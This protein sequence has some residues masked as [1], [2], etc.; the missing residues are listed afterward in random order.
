M[1]SINYAPADE[2]MKVHGIGQEIVAKIEVMRNAKQWITRDDFLKIPHTRAETVDLLDFSKN[3]NTEN[4]V[5]GETTDTISGLDRGEE[6]RSLSAVGSSDPRTS[7]GPNSTPGPRPVSYSSQDMR[8][9]FGQGK[10]TI[11]DHGPPT[12][13]SHPPPGSWAYNPGQPPQASWSHIQSH[14]PQGSWS[15]PQGPP[16]QVAWSL[17]QG[18]RP[19]QSV[20]EEQL[21]RIVKAQL[22]IQGHGSIP[23]PTSTTT[24]N[25]SGYGV[26]QAQT[27][28]QD[29]NL[30]RH[31]HRHENW[32]NEHSIRTPQPKNLK[33]PTSIFFDGSS[34]FNFFGPCSPNSST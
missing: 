16:P 23:P 20:D 11:P 2:L 32:D 33:P 19:N 22:Q 12:H 29:R 3:C 13:L 26:N 1:V 18:Q 24:Q 14:Q 28:R 9:N 10:S 31:P 6:T 21:V 27:H 5:E 15:H 25:Q 7:Q 17:T 8:N 30:E 4:R 34:D